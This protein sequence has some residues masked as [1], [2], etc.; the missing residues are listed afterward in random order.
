M[1]LAL[2]ALRAAQ[3]YRSHP[4]TGDRAWSAASRLRIGGDANGGVLEAEQT[5]L[6]S[7][8][9]RLHRWTTPGRYR[10]S[11]DGQRVLRRWRRSNGQ[12]QSRNRMWKTRRRKSRHR[13]SC[14]IG[15]RRSIGAK[16]ERRAH[17]ARDVSAASPIRGRRY[18][19]RWS[20]RWSKRWKTRNLMPVRLGY[21]C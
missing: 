10:Q 7:R 11:F 2:V 12:S 14:R 3:G 16:H 15:Q 6:V 17:W 4:A 13:R 8:N 5:G 1:R 18:E 19:K 21:R 9:P 20:I